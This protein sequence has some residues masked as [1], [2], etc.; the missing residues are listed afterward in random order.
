MN[1]SNICY[2]SLYAFTYYIFG[3]VLFGMHQS[4]TLLLRFSLWDKH[5]SHSLGFLHRI[6]TMMCKLA[7]AAWVTASLESSLTPNLTTTS[8]AFPALAG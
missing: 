7:D 5:G 6:L 4:F 1:L 3:K 8:T 2:L